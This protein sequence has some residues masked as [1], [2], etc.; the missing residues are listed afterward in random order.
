MAETRDPELKA[1]VKHAIEK[2][3]RDKAIF[4]VPSSTEHT[5]GGRM[6]AILFGISSA[7]F[8][9]CVERAPFL[10]TYDETKASQKLL[11]PGAKEAEVPLGTPLGN[12]LAWHMRNSGQPPRGL[13]AVRLGQDRGHLQEYLLTSPSSSSSSSSWR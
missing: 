4:L 10:Q 5:Q 12:L 2:A 11:Q 8:K 6:L 9:V 3:V 7:L 1:L 13:V